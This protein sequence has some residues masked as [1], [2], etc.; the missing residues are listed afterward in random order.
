MLRAEGASDANGNEGGGAAAADGDAT[1]LHSSFD[2]SLWSNTGG[3][4]RGTPSA[5]K[6]VGG[7]GSYTWASTDQLVLDVQSWINDPSENFG[8]ALVG[9][10]S[11]SRTAKRFASRTFNDSDKW[12]VIAVEFSTP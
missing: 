12:P 10:E 4:Y 3:D 9:D 1:W 2:S 6:V 11:S 7:T 5:V 8:W